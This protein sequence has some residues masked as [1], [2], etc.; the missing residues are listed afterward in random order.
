MDLGIY[1]K[2][3][4]V[5]GASSGIGR[6]VALDLAAEGADVAVLARRRDRL[7]T[8][9]SEALEKYG[10]NLM[11][12][13]G[14]VTDPT[15]SRRVEAEIVNSL[16]SLEIFVHAAGGHVKATMGSP[17]SSWQSAM[18]LNFNAARWLT[19]TVAPMM[20]GQGF[21]RIVYIT[22]KSEPVSV[23]AVHC[24]KAALH[25]WSKGL[26]RQLGAYGVTVNSVAPGRIL[27]DQM[28]RDY[29]SDQRREHEHEIP[30]G[31]YGTT[32]ELSTMVLTLCAEAGGYV[33]GTVIPVDGSLRKYQF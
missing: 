14:D 20:T 4:L 24:A 12:I 22:G 16:G 21:G 31:R 10:K 9:Q 7:L 13:S 15:T 3:A 1:G 28:L 11:I 33:S 23:S 17:E 29:T 32:R 2:R 5:T 8:L 6:Q 18:D 25:A 27:T 26:S 19:D 30:L